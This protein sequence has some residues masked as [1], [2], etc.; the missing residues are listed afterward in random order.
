MPGSMLGAVGTEIA[1]PL[2]LSSDGWVGRGNVTGHKRLSLMTGRRGP[3]KREVLSQLKRAKEGFLEEASE[4][5]ALEDNS[6]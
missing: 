1:P 6:D 3:G 5:C 2:P 4:L